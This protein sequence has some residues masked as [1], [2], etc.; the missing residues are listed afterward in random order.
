MYDE[1]DQP[2]FWESV[3]ALDALGDHDRIAW[4]IGVLRD[5]AQRD[6]KSAVP[7]DKGI[8][9]LKLPSTYILGGMSRPLRLAFYLDEQPRLGFDGVVVFLH[10]ETYDEAEELMAGDSL[11]PH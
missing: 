10:V 11:P 2:L 8:R 6:P 1:E 9:V 5:W 3:D 4:G 7:N